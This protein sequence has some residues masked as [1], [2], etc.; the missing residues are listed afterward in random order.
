MTPAEITQRLQS[1]RRNGTWWIINTPP[2]VEESGLYD[3][4]RECDEDR[5]GIARFIRANKEL[6]AAPIDNPQ[7]VVQNVFEF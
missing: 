3:T 7:A 1:V 2:G 6:F 4:R 5:R